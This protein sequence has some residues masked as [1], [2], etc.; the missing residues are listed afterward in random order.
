MSEVVVVEERV[1]CVG[2]DDEVVEETDVNEF[3]SLL[4]G[5]GDVL[6]FATWL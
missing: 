6:I 4:Y 5:I 2:G 3:A 1:V